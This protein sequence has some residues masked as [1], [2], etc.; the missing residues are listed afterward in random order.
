MSFPPD[1]NAAMQAMLQAGNAI[2]QCFSQF[3]SE[4]KRPSVP[5]ARHRPGSSSRMR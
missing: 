4:Q 1:Q 2:A 5:T 3:L